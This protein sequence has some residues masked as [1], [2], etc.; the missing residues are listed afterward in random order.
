MRRGIRRIASAAAT[1][2]AVVTLAGFAAGPASAVVVNLIDNA[3]IGLW[4]SDPN[5]TGAAYYD[6]TSAIDHTPSDLGWYGF[7]A[8][9]TS[10]SLPFRID[11]LAGALKPDPLVSYSLGVTNLT[12]LTQRYTFV[13]TLPLAPAITAADQYSVRSTMSGGMV[14]VGGD[15]I[16]ITSTTIPSPTLQRS[17]VDT[18]GIFQNGASET[19]L[20]VG[21]GLDYVGMFGAYGPYA[22]GVVPGIVGNWNYLHLALSFDLSAGDGFSPSGMTE[23]L[24]TPLPAPLPLLLAGLAGVGWLGARRPA[25][26]G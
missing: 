14:D 15:G 12:A 19:E 10:A 26:R 8:S 4:V 24:P 20:P 11:Y 13:F 17:W 23:I 5:G 18:D 25:T 21:I 16:S 2:A 1:V 6:M 22:T 7:S 9:L 3:R